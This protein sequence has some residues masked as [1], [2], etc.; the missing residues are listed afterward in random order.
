MIDMTSHPGKD[1]SSL[2]QLVSNA[3]SKLHLGGEH[4]RVSVVSFGRLAF[5][6]LSLDE[7]VD[8]QAVKR[9]L[10]ETTVRGEVAN[11][12]GALWVMQ[13][14]V[15]VESHGD[16]ATAPN[17]AVLVTDSRHSIAISSHAVTK[18]AR[19]ARDNGIPLCVVAIDDKVDHGLLEDMTESNDDLF[20]VG[21][22]SGFRDDSTASWL[23]SKIRQLG[24][25]TDT[26]THARTH[27]RT[28]T[29]ARTHSRTHARTTH[30]F[31]QITAILVL[32]QKSVYFRR[33]HM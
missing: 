28:H 27:A 21:G 31:Q 15:F 2:K 33:A 9:T 24:K 1:H 8:T 29:R 25:Y 6:Q 16:R 10:T 26:R 22:Y 30:T 13:N 20:Y 32:R 18:S 23:A 12:F 3:M 5:T 14:S 17:V 7:G 19:Q 4:A 11:Y